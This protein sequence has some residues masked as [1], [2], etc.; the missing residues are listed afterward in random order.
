MKRP[1]EVFKRYTLNPQPSTLSPQPYV[2]V[3]GSIGSAWKRQIAA[4]LRAVYPTLIFSSHGKFSSK[5]K[6]LAILVWILSV[7]TGTAQAVLFL[8]TY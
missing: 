3:R 7:R 4:F 5:K 2:L 1:H 8:Y 6:K